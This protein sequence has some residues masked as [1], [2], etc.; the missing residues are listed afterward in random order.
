MAFTERKEEKMEKILSLRERRFTPIELLVVIAIIAI[1]AAMLLPALNRAREA[2]RKSSCQSNLKQQMT[3]TLMYV[4]TN[5]FYPCLNNA[6]TYGFAGWKWQIAPYIGIKVDDNRLT[7][8]TLARQEIKLAQGPFKCPSQMSVL[9]LFTGKEL[10]LGGYGYNWYGNGS[11]GTCSGMGY[12]KVYVRPNRVKKPTETITIADSSD[13][14][15]SADQAAALYPGNNPPL[16]FR[17][18]AE[19]N[20][21]FADG[22]VG[23]MNE[24][25]ARLIKGG[26]YYYF[27]SKDKSL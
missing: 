21:G 4:D 2:A 10:Y 11:D 1:L 14:P 15:S 12:L 13:S 16:G 8:S 19:M 18:S 23:S 25:K 6:G 5:D 22:H 20:I 7:V 3:G 9:P 17:H 24:T 26:V 27:Y